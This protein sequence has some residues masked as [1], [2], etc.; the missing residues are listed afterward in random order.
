MD[1]ST[2]LHPVSLCTKTKVE[3]E[4]SV[5]DCM[6]TRSAGTALRFATVYGSSPRMRFDPPVH[7]FT[8]ELLLQRR[9]QVYGE[10]LWQPYVHVADVARAVQ[11]GLGAP[12]RLV[13]G[14]V[15]NVGDTR[16]NYTERQLVE[17]IRHF[18]PRCEI[19]YQR[20]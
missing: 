8:R 16:E 11:R 20:P 13:R 2:P 6:T 3:T 15:F 1:E 12:H 19:E 14:E 7:E 4:H 9:L 17:H 18:V 10:N 5:N